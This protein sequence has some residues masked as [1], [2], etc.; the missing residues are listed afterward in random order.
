M[1]RLQTKKHPSKKYYRRKPKK[2][3]CKKCREFTC[4]TKFHEKK[5]PSILPTAKRRFFFSPFPP[6]LAWI[7]FFL[8][9]GFDAFVIGD[10][11]A[12]HLEDGFSQG[13]PCGVGTDL[14]ETPKVWE[15]SIGVDA[16]DG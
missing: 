3:P 12:E 4:F 5:L 15:N 1:S 10:D 16:R 13:E 2:K 8:Q 9:P 6:N 11:E 14:G 7:R